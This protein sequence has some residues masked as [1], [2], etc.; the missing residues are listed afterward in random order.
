MSAMKKLI[1]VVLLCRTA[2]AQ[3][4]P[5]HGP[6]ISVRLAPEKA[7]FMLGEPGYVAFVVHNDSAEKLAVVFGGD[8]QNSLGRPDNFKIE[9]RD[10]KGQLVPQPSAGQTTGGME[11]PRDLPPHGDC[12][13]SLFLPHWATFS[14]PGT[15]IMRC[16]K[17]LPILPAGTH[18]MDWFKNTTN[19]PVEARIKIKIVPR[20]NAK[21]GALIARWGETMLRHPNT[22]TGETA[23]Q[24]LRAIHDARVVPYFVRGAREGGHE[25]KGEALMAL[26]KYNSDAALA[27]IKSC[28]KVTGKQLLDESISPDLVDGS[29]REIR[30]AAARALSESRHPQALSLLLSMRHDSYYAVR[31]EVVHKLGTLR[32]PRARQLLQEL[33]R[34]KNHDV[35]DEARRYLSKVKAPAE[36]R[37]I[38]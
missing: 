21:M 22:E 4:G 7:E 11:G 2:F 38:P 13:V 36:S 27:G 34:D 35:A 24:Q 3:P 32:T 8:Y 37:A 26:P 16:R 6:H 12:V 23:A 10:A 1:L 29:A 28:M 14:A 31:L 18:V 20:D 17:T 30:H 9:V 25:L 15:Y 19:F 5:D 33:T